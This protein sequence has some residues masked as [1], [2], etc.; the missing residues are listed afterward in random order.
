MIDDT[1]DFEIVTAPEANILC[2][3]HK[4]ATCDDLD[5]LNR[6]LRDQLLRSG[7][8]YIVQTQLCGE[9]W[10]RITI[11]NPATTTSDLEQLLERL[12]ELA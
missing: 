2:F 7:E 12:R 11:M 8:F 1:D 10:L 3:R 4:P 6:R 9:T 5:A